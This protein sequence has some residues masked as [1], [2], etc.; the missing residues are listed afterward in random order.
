MAC[1]PRKTTWFETHGITLVLKIT[2]W[3]GTNSHSICITTKL[4]TG[5]SILYIIFPIMFRHPGAF[6]K[7]IQEGI[8]HVF[9]KTLPAI[10]PGFKHSY[11][12]PCAQ[13]LHGFTIQFHSIDRVA[14][15]TTIVHIE[16]SIVI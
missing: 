14:V 16:F 9:T 6:N 1:T 5:C 10:A 3:I 11:L 8:I 4:S 12:Y 7:W 15:A 2:K 13:W